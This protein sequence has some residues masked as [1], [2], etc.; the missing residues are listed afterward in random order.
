MHQP[1]AQSSKTSVIDVLYGD[2]L[3]TRNVHNAWYAQQLSGG[4]GDSSTGTC[5]DCLD[6][7]EFPNSILGCDTAK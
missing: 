3:T 6:N 7:I 1:S 4:D 2:Q 5:P